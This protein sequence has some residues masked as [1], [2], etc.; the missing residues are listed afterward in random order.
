MELLFKKLLHY[1]S[2]CLEWLLGVFLLLTIYATNFLAFPFTRIPVERKVNYKLKVQLRAVNIA[3]VYRDIAEEILGNKPIFFSV[4]RSNS[5]EPFYLYISKKHLRELPSDL[6][7]F[8]NFADSLAKH[9]TLILEVEARKSLLNGH[10]PADILNFEISNEKP[11][12]AK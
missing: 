12:V 2:T 3:C 1:S 4:D 6:I 9:Q 7:H 8:S 10:L 5:T 11:Q